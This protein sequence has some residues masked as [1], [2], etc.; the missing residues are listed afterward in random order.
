[1]GFH[2][3]KIHTN[4]FILIEKR[5]ID[6]PAWVQAGRVGRD[7]YTELKRNYNGFNNGQLI[8]CY[9][10]MRKKYGYG[11][12]TLSNGFKKLIEL[13]L[14]ELV[15]YGQLAGLSGKKASKYRLVGK[16]EKIIEKNS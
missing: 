2:K 11:F 6:S 9:P 15:E 1:M 5:L 16:H 13:E 3:K 10:F 8:C 4:P 14:I 7:I 12:G